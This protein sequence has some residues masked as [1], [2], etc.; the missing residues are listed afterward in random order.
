MKRVFTIVIGFVHD[1]A[2]GCWAAALFSAYWLRRSSG[3]YPELIAPL[4]TLQRN[5]FYFG[6]GCIAVVLLAGVGRTF[7]YA[8]IG[9]VYGEDAE[10]LRRKM[11]ITK[12]VV[13]FTVFGA[14]TF[15]HYLLA[16][17]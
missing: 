4:S 11:L 5:F 9:N 1:F 12:H 13:L 2:A 14:G 17:R 7:T 6:L 15:W 3:E 16:F 8:Y 10:K